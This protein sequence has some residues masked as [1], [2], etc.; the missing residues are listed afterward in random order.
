MTCIGMLGGED[1]GIMN[2][3]LTLDGGIGYPV[4][5]L[6][7]GKAAQAAGVSYIGATYPYSDSAVLGQLNKGNYVIVGM[8]H[9]TTHADGTVTRGP[10]FVVVTGA[11]INPVTHNCDFKIDDPAGKFQYLNTY[12]TNSSQN[13]TLTSV[14]V[15]AP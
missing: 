10:H 3:L 9:N 7:D 11:G 5:N 15:F 4:P 2:T 6:D 13:G 1:P 12:V 14:R 8:L